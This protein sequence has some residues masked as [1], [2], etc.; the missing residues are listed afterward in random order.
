MRGIF[1]RLLRLTTALVLLLPMPAYAVTTSHTESVHFFDALHGYI[2]GGF[3]S[4]TG[5]V[6]TTSDGGQTWH[7]TAFPNA[8]IMG[9]DGTQ[10]WAVSSYKDAAYVSA[11]GGVT[12]STK[13]PVI[14]SGSANFSDVA[15]LNGGRVA[16]VGQRTSTARGDLALITTSDDGGSIWT[17][18]F[19]GPLYPAPDEFTDP[20]K[21]LS[22][23]DSIET[24][25]VGKVAWAVGNEFTPGS[26]ADG[27]TITFAG[28]LVKRTTD[29][30][31]TWVTQTAPA[32]ASTFV[33]DIAVES[34]TLAYI[35]CTGRSFYRTADGG[36]TWSRYQIPRFSY[37]SLIS[38]DVYSVDGFGSNLLVLGGMSTGGSAMF[39][40]SR[41]PTDVSANSWKSAYLPGV[42]PIR[43][44]Q[45]LSETHWVAVGDNETIL[46]TYDGGTTWSGSMSPSAPASPTV[47]IGSPVTG[48]VYASQIATVSGAS[49]DGSGTG[50][51]AV[52][53][54]ISRD[55]GAY[56]T[57]TAW[58]V[59]PVWLRAS[60]LDGWSH[61]DYQWP[62]EP[63]QI[64]ANT[65]SVTARAT[66]AVGNV[67]LKQVGG[68]KVVNPTGG[69]GGGGSVATTLT[70]SRA[71]SLPGV[72][73]RPFYAPPDAAR[74][75]D[76]LRLESTGGDTTITAMT[77][78]GKDTA[79]M[80]Y[81]D[82]KWIRLY[83]DDGDGVWD[84]GDTVLT[85]ARRFTIAR[86]TQAI[87]FS[88]LSV[89]IA[90]GQPANVW[91]VMAVGKGAV[92]GHAIGSYVLQGDVVSTAT[93]SYPFPPPLM[94]ANRGATMVVRR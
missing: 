24:T 30:G 56:W 83:R 33:N 50:V 90:E 43:S 48:E 35:G 41:T 20:P 88:N 86:T 93:E 66:D 94:S 76:A 18:R 91:I 69:G 22:S 39:A 7:A 85:P 57:G 80:L 61:W 2:G 81:T 34:T 28:P 46:H 27:S 58:G 3:G 77:V 53:L 38:M 59:S 71:T 82:A 62:L 51:A 19:E 52:D 29:G 60:T 40:W 37:G 13:S 54:T 78:R 79:P 15:V 55:D 73:Q 75:I 64:G 11:D 6:S 47:H 16:V 92:S 26:G 67:S 14:S 70:V 49:S 84:S 32:L 1:G 5:F 12:Y 31:S 8:W 42:S 21:T 74:A 87:T 25:G 44:I 45:V 9:V 17:K 72:P 63:N 10:P 36:T 65:Y 23:F 89:K 4:S 68:I